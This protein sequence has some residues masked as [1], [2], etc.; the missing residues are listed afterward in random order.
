MRSILQ[1][2]RTSG[3]LEFRAIVTDAQG[4]VKLNGAP[5]RL[6]DDAPLYYFRIRDFIKAI[7]GGTIPN[8]PIHF[9][10]HFRVFTYDRASKRFDR[11]EA[12]TPVTQPGEV[13]LAYDQCLLFIHDWLEQM[14]EWRKE[15]A[16]SMPES[17]TVLQDLAECPTFEMLVQYIFQLEQACFDVAHE[18]VVKRPTSNDYD[19]AY[20]IS[21]RTIATFL[22][23]RA[24]AFSTLKES[25]H[26]IGA[27]DAFPL[28]A[29]LL[30]GFLFFQKPEFARL[31]RP[32]MQEN[33][34]L[35]GFNQEE[36]QKKMH[37][38]DESIAKC[39]GDKAVAEV[40]SDDAVPSHEKAAAE[41]LDA[42][43]AD[44]LAA[45]K[46]KEAKRRK[47]ERRRDAKQAIVTKVPSVPV[48]D[49]AVLV[50][51][52]EPTTFQ[53]RAEAPVFVPS[54]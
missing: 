7:C 21:V 8:V 49:T 50:L 51:N 23:T 41:L 32:H 16:W 1:L 34:L 46:K 24:L 5:A 26:P 42:E 36:L 40:S 37:Q 33:V 14:T 48:A 29:F 13:Y 19:K 2:V 15:N 11:I 27:I 38:I 52:Q 3:Q 4:V 30:E 53:L 20:D 6:D 22:E 47:R 44:A 10:A 43:A 18:S 45:K 17:V 35:V 9:N 54:Q 28:A 12:G 31:R 39:Y 25:I